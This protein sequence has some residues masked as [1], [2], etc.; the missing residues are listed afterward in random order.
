MNGRNCLLHPA[1]SCS[2][3]QG[4]HVHQ[5]RLQARGHRANRCRRCCARTGATTQ[6]PR[7]T[8]KYNLTV[9][10]TLRGDTERAPE[11]LTACLAFAP[12]DPI[13]WELAAQQA[14]ARGGVRQTLRDYR[15][16]IFCTRE[17]G[18][19]LRLVRLLLRHGRTR[20]AL[21]MFE[22]CQYREPGHAGTYW[23]LA[24]LFAAIGQTARVVEACQLAPHSTLIPSFASASRDTNCSAR[25]GKPLR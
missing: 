5:P 22:E 18:S 6:P 16:A 15:R 17:V 8:A 24:E 10:F 23:L 2:R 19:Q 1:G 20:E 21:A 11:K 25:D 13:G 3:A 7:P 4:T 14:E 9:V 12:D